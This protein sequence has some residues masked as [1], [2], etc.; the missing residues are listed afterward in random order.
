[1]TTDAQAEQDRVEAEVAAAVRANPNILTRDSVAATPAI[2]AD[3]Q[4]TQ[5]RV[6]AEVAA[7]VGPPPTTLRRALDLEL[8]PATT[9]RFDDA[10]RAP[11]LAGSV[12]GPDGQVWPPPR[13]VEAVEPAAPA[14][15]RVDPGAWF[16]TNEGR[17]LDEGWDPPTPDIRAVLESREALRSAWRRLG[18]RALND[19]GAIHDAIRRADVDGIITAVVA[20]AVEVALVAVEGQPDHVVHMASAQL[21]AAWRRLAYHRRDALLAS[22]AGRHS[23]AAERLRR[24][25]EV[26]G[27]LQAPPGVTFPDYQL[28]RV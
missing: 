22:L 3:A 25:L 1:M 19:A 7:A 13:A 12:F 4:A 26:L 28:R 11:G 9:T 5:D 16:G 21:E 8:R 2:V 10:V 14:E 17:L 24:G 20:N 15:E 6:E 23:P 18:T 27:R